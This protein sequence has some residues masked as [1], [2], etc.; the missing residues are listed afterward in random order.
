MISVV[1][2]TLNDER[3]LTGTLA[4]LVPAA[5][6]GFVREVIL[7]D[8]GSND[9]TREIADDAGAVIVEAGL[10]GACHQAKEPWLLV[11]D[12]GARLAPGWEAVAHAHTQASPQRAGRIELGRAAGL[13]GWLSRRLG[14]STVVGV[15][16]PEAMCAEPGGGVADLAAS[17]P[18]RHSVRLDIGAVLEA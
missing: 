15:L 14:R 12:P 9:S 17:I 18:R 3:R 10:A 6:D 16:A 2:A 1:I 4:A 5:V 11:L 7:A 8:G 13:G